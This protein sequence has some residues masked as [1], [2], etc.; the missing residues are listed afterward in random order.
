MNLRGC[1]V[2]LLAVAGA[3][4]SAVG[5][6]VDAPPPVGW[7]GDQPVTRSEWLEALRQQLPVHADEA[8][9]RDAA[10]AFLM[11]ERALWALA[12]ESGL[13]A[14]ENELQL[15]ARHSADTASRRARLEAGQTLYGP[16]QLPWPAFRRHRTA[17]LRHALLR[18]LQSQSAP[19]T[20]DLRAFYHRNPALFTNAAGHPLPFDEYRDHVIRCFLEDCLEQRIAAWIDRTPMRWLPPD[21]EIQT[22]NNSGE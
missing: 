13:D 8:Q 17:S 18:T 1:S 5:E 2:V 3:I 4:G 16:L 20:E 19:L 9:A 10:R 15:R 12:A 11:R 6:V 14:V 21:A 7:I 22:A